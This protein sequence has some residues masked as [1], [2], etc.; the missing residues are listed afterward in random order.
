MKDV[1]IFKRLNQF[2]Q[3]S[4]KISYFWNQ[5][6]NIQLF[7]KLGR[8]LIGFS[9]FFNCFS[10]FSNQEWKD[11]NDFDSSHSKCL[12]VRNASE[13]CSSFRNERFENFF[14]LEAVDSL[15]LCIM[16]ISVKNK[17]IITASILVLIHGIIDN[18]MN[19]LCTVENW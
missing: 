18:F 15:N 5:S 17:T 2:E 10:L 12:S 19:F 13:F 16:K 4:E 9:V 11:L 1:V 6:M 8:H 14:Y 7:D 3:N